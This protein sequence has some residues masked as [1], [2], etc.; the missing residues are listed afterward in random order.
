MAAQTP[1][2]LSKAAQEGVCEYQTQCA[3]MMSRNWNIRSQ[4]AYID[5][6]YMREGNLETK[7]IRAEIANALGLKNKLQDPV[8][9]IVM[10]QVENTL[11]YLASVFLS[12]HP[13]F[14]VVADPT[15][16]DAAIQL[17]TVIEENARRGGWT[18]EFI[19]WMRDGLKYNLQ[20]MEL[21]WGR[22]TIFNPITDTS[23]DPKIAAQKKVLWEGNI[24][25]RIDLYNAYWDTRVEPSKIHE[26]GEFAGYNELFTRMRLKQFI[27]D[28]PD[29]MTE[30]VKAAFESMVDTGIY[31]WWYTPMINP[32]ALLNYDP[33]TTMDWLA[34]ATPEA[35]NGKIQYNNMY[36]VSTLYARIIPSDFNIR[37]P[38]QNTP[39]IWKFIFVN[40][41]VL[42]YAERQTDAHANLPII[43]GQPI[44]DGLRY[45]TKSYASNGIPFQ[46][47]ASAL[48][49]AKLASERRKIGDRVLF[50]PLLINE[51]DINSD[52]PS[53]KIPVRPNAY[54][55]PLAE[56]VYAF[57]YNDSTLNSLIPEAQAIVQMADILNG[58]NQVR[59][60]QFVKGNKT[61]SQFQQTMQ[62]SEGR[63]QMLALFMEAQS[64]TPFKEMMMLNIL[65]YQPG[66]AIYSPNQQK[67]VTIDPVQLRNAQLIFKVTDGMLPLERLI[68]TDFLIT[69]LQIISADPELALEY[70]KA[71]IVAYIAKLKG[72]KHLADFKRTEE[73]RSQIIKYQE[74][75]AA[76]EQSK[77]GAN[78]GRAAG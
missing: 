29:A 49:A 27:A 69:F 20:A 23:F 19:L 66:G 5:T 2:L 28:L 48:W 24:A 61:N 39:Q 40:Q 10:P 7:Q 41:R 26:V 8:V 36:I 17:E 31:T 54:G 44:E 55:R 47:M 33:L 11:T 62:S 35:R 4:M 77:K 32:K 59:Q 30:N 63:D 75:V 1:I 12:A 13:L 16:Q 74:A 73:E 45:Q 58:K 53:A 21:V 15:N 70:D 52:N 18:R 78:G 46:D 65:Q 25:R 60:G 3:N 57:P 50:N 22:K 14:G 43:F 42:I 71:D 72:I 9:P 34:W 76:Q 67:V 51:K 37:V 56:A 68:E 38:S 6:Q 64:F